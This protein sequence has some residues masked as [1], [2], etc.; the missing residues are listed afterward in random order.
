[1]ILLYLHGTCKAEAHCTKPA[2][3][4][5]IKRLE[6]FL[7]EIKCNKLGQFR[8]LEF[9]FSKYLD[10]RLADELTYLARGIYGLIYREK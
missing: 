8:T 2:P 9:T 7:R 1:M 3:K 4:I 5:K 6:G 10:N